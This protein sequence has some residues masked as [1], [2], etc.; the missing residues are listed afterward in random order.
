MLIYGKGSTA[1]QRRMTFKVMILEKADFHVG[2][3]EGKE[4]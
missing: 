1:E 2:R 3:K 4:E